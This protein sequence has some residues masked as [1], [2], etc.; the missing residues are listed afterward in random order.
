M[1]L[2][3]RWHELKSGMKEEAVS[4]AETNFLQRMVSLLLLNIKDGFYNIIE[5]RK[6]GNQ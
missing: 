5:K 4:M 2:Y 1:Q 6:A 3:T